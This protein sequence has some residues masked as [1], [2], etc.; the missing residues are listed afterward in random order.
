MIR[1]RN[2]RYNTKTAGRNALPEPGVNSLSY[3]SNHL[4]A[5][6][7][8]ANL[9]R[10]HR[11]TDRSIAPSAKTLSSLVG[12]FQINR[13]AHVRRTEEL[14]RQSFQPDEPI[15]CQD[16]LCWIKRGTVQIRHSR[17][18]YKIKSLSAGGVFG[19]MPLLGQTM[20]VTE[21]V[22][23]PQGAGIAVMTSADA[24]R[25]IR[26]DPISVIGL[27][28]RKLAET[29]WSYYRS[30]FQRDDSRVAALLLNVAGNGT[31][32]DGMTQEALGEKLA[33][34]RETVNTILSEL[35]SLGL[36][37]T[38]KRK[39]TILDKDLLKALSEF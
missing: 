7:K 26:T 28:G 9:S 10:S 6:P 20:L 31:V 2:V 3:D 16:I 23:G 22:A 15:P 11:L 18:K 29:E 37:Q 12:D 8:L 38:D 14:A 4:P 27:I 17:H 34:Y 24:A 5:S 32:I 1:D 33:I 30:R 13:F 35:C 39:I 25:W 36:I 21:A 19:E